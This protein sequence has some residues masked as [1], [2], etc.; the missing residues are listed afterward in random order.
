[1][2][3][4]YAITDSHQESRNL[5]KLLSGIYNIEKDL[6]KPFLVL[7]AG[8]LFK[9]IYDKELSVNAYIK[10]KQLL[11]QA[12][13]FITLGNNDFGFTKTDFEY[14]KKIAEKFKNAGINIICANLHPNF[15]SKY[16]IIE[17]NNEKLL[18]TGFCLNNS[19]AKKFKCELTTPENEL[20]SLIQN[21]TEDFD[22]II[23]LNHNWYPYSK[24]LK[25]AAQEIGYDIELIIGGHEHS[26][27]NPDFDNM[28]FYPLSFARSMFKFKLDKK[29]KKIQE[30]SLNEIDFI[31]E[32][33]SPIL[34]YEEKT[35]LK[36]PIAK[37]V[38][39]LTK[40]YSDPC[41][42]GTFISDNMKRIGNSD[43]AFHS[44]G[45]SMYPLRKEDSENITMY[46]LKQVMC[47]SETNIEKVEL[48]T[49][50][51]K[52]VFENATSWR[53]YKDRGNSKFLQCSQNITI[54][55]I[56]N[57]SDKTYKIIQIEINGEKLLDEQQTPIN[58]ERKFSCTI[59]N[60][61]GNGE[62][63]FEMLK[64]ITKTKILENDKP[65][66]ISELFYNSVINAPNKY[67]QPEY[68]TFKIID[69]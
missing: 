60:Y 49:M 16:K 9:G 54:T 65:I 63:G 4:I 17:I 2:T 18:I 38:L 19:C 34:E 47:K 21:I 40:C 27:I 53:M 39:N 52:E 43:I 25:E 23:V 36:K 1:M 11:P 29:I 51:L 13:I 68:P 56:G 57:T 35:E 8:D 5:S 14:L 62:Q 66:L 7:D 6:N 69:L 3:N 32:F 15:V 55:G 30:I 26:P 22:K 10:L 42:L 28:I 44:T 24:K 45:F 31:N 41:P 58:P 37:R 50:Q 67:T 61:V 59:D 64:D 33:E 48:T 20:K 12:E 46:D